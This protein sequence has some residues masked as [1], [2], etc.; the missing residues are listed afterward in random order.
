MS[1]EITYLVGLGFLQQIDDLAQQLLV[2][3][4][5]LR[6][7]VA[8]CLARLGT[9]RA[10]VLD[11]SLGSSLSAALGFRARF[12]R[13]LFRLALVRLALALLAFALCHRSRGEVDLRTS[14]PRALGCRRVV[15]RRS[16]LPM[17]DGAN[18]FALT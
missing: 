15:G 18:E 16:E 4:D 8:G 14:W 5:L 7:G 9:I 13:L 12:L 11:R 10:F 1:S 3:G 2:L 6:G 17:T